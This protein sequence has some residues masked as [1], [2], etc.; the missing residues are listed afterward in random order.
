MAITFT[1][2]KDRTTSPRW[3]VSSSFTTM[4]PRP[5]LRAAAGEAEVETQLAALPIVVPRAQGSA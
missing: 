1:A 5:G 2:S 3:L 4:M